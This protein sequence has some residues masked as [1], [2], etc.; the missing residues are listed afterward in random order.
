[1]AKVCRRCG[2]KLG[3]L[4]SVTKDGLC[5]P[6]DQEVKKAKEAQKREA[7]S[8]TNIIIDYIAKT[9]TINDK[10]YSYLESLDPT[11]QNRVYVTLV[12]RFLATGELG[13]T[14]GEI[15]VSLFKHLTLDPVKSTLLN[16]VVPSLYVASIRKEEALPVLPREALT[17]DI[18]FKKGE[19]PHYSCK[20]VLKENKIV[21]TGYQSGSQGVSIRVMKG[22]SYR[23]GA[24]RGH[25]TREEQVV[26]TSRGTLLIT[27]Q[28]FFLH[29]ESNTKPLSIP[30]N[31]IL[32]YKCY[33]DGIVLYKEGREKPFIIQV[34][35]AGEAETIGLCL[36]YLTTNI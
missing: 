21:K 15:L 24:T 8:Q 20:A 31:K 3:F 34:N 25:I 36:G 26:E 35:H 32:S 6:C 17:Q 16:R 11:E 14:E 12:D 29:P 13:D 2:K 1:M 23:V 4:S 30:I 18:I 22:V 28:R 27:N 10:Q 9:G 5:I 33:D 7:V 19:L